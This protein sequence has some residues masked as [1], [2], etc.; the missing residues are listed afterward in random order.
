MALAGRLDEGLPKIVERPFT[1]LLEAIERIGELN[2]EQGGDDRISATRRQVGYAI[3]CHERG[4][5]CARGKAEWVER[6]RTSIARRA[7]DILN[8]G[9]INETALNDVWKEAAACGVS[10]ATELL[11]QALVA[12]GAR[13]AREAAELPDG[14]ERAARAAEAVARCERA[15]EGRPDLREAHAV[16]ADAKLLL[17]RQAVGEKHDQ[18]FREVF[19]H[20]EAAVAH[21]DDG[22][23]GMRMSDDGV[24]DVTI[25]PS[26]PPHAASTYGRWA[27]ALGEYAEGKSGE[28]KERLLAAA[29]AKRGY[30]GQKP[31]H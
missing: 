2:A 20:Y 6:L 29:A 23:E 18:L 27:E 14:D 9:Q 11:V 16:C 17:A 21:I 31:Q 12:D 25:S 1:Y 22:Y 24:S 3:D 15:L 30:A 28:E 26:L 5:M 7:Q 13:L 10:E 19:G 8:Y 4:R